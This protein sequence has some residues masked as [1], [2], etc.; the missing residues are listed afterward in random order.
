MQKMKYTSTH[1]DHELVFGTRGAISF[2][3][4]VIYVL[5]CNCVTYDSDKYSV[6]YLEHAHNKGVD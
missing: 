4:Y 6:L 2:V 3:D 1:H 5:D